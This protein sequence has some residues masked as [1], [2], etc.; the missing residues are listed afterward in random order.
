MVGFA[1]FLPADTMANIR[2]IGAAVG[3]IIAT[4]MATQALRKT[5]VVMPIVSPAPAFIPG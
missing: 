2:I 5:A 1:A 3:N 4:I